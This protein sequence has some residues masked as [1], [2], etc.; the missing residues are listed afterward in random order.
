[1]FLLVLPVDCSILKYISLLLLLLLWSWANVILVVSRLRAEQK[2]NPG[3]IS[4]KVRH[5]C[6]PNIQA[7]TGAQP[8]SSLFNGLRRV[9]SPGVKRPPFS[10]KVKNY[11]DLYLHS[12]YAFMTSTGKILPSLLSVQLPWSLNTTEQTVKFDSLLRVKV[13]VAGTSPPTFLSSNTEGFFCLVKG[14]RRVEMNL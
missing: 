5:F 14:I 2:R 12:P 10:I 13:T 8:A 3:L 9:P 1:M 4:G 7:G 6:H 11:M